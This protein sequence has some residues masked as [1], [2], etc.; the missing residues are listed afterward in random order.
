M[1]E[2]LLLAFQGRYLLDT[3]LMQIIVLSYL[4]IMIIKF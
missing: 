4:N 2:N 3:L 1:N